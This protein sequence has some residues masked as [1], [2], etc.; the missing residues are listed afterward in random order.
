MKEDT[1]SAVALAHS[2]EC[3]KELIS[4]L[5][6]FGSMETF[7]PRAE[8][9]NVLGEKTAADVLPLSL[10]SGL[11]LCFVGSATQVYIYVYWTGRRETKTTI[12]FGY[13]KQSSGA[14]LL[15]AGLVTLAAVSTTD[16]SRRAILGV[17]AVEGFIYNI[18]HIIY[19]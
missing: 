17:T 15:E 16:R 7:G 5:P 9:R 8:K 10:L 12:R 19:R 1:K 3:T 11:F 4:G 13:S 2:Q 18:G 6:N 14:Y